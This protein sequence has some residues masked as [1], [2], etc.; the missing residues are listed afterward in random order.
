LRR[1][2][3]GVR[4]QRWH[5]ITNRSGWQGENRKKVRDLKNHG[6]TLRSRVKITFTI[7]CLL[8]KAV[9]ALRFIPAVAKCTVQTKAGMKRSAMTE[10]RCKGYLG[11]V[12]KRVFSKF[13]RKCRSVLHVV[14]IRF[15]DSAVRRPC[16][17]KKSDAGRNLPR[18]L[19][20]NLQP[21]RPTWR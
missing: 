4:H 20:V 21:V 6:S 18:R 3:L 19:V 11:T 14:P 10:Y 2:A 8:R 13:S 12:P 17:K 5:S 7:S 9:I 1:W 15:C 16:R